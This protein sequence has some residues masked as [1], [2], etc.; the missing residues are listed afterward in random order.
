MDDGKFKAMTH[1][2]GQELPP[3]GTEEDKH[4]RLKKKK[5]DRFLSSVAY[6][7]FILLLVL[8]VPTSAVMRRA[9]T[10]CWK[11]RRDVVADLPCF[12]C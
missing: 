7:K 8:Y 2:V 4:I 10:F 5:K 11:A 12:C 9:R 1:S 6:F 3:G